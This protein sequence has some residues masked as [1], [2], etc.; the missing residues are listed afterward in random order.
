MLRFTVFVL[1]ASLSISCSKSGQSK[2][3]PK[4]D[5]S[6]PEGAILCLE[7]A[8]RE[9]DLVAAVASKDFWLEAREMLEEIMA[10]GKDKS[11][12]TDELIKET[13]E[14]LELA[15]R[16][17]ITKEGFPDFEGLRSTFPKKINLKDDIYRVTE[18]C[19]FPDGGKS[20]QDLLVGFRNGE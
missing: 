3:S 11:V 1:L 9:G 6:T 8:F 2:S 10:D 19:F 18:V 14:T 5:F 12:L 7:N 13:A 20:E 16:V 4:A 17:Q 15:F